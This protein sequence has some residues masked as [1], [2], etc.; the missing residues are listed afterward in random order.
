MYMT[1]LVF[2]FSFVLFDWLFFVSLN[3]AKDLYA[4]VSLA[5]L[6][7]LKVSNRKLLQ[8]LEAVY[9]TQ[10]GNSF[11][12]SGTPFKDYVIPV[13]TKT[14]SAIGLLKGPIPFGHQWGLGG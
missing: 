13:D 8:K 2:S 11:P 9:F 12:I 4:Y 1:L 14:R 3:Y 6:F 10:H 7:C 5:F